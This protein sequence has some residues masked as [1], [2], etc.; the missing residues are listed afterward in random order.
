MLGHHTGFERVLPVYR[1]PTRVPEQVT[2]VGILDAVGI[3]TSDRRHL[4]GWR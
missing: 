3:P 1:S 4:V 2:L